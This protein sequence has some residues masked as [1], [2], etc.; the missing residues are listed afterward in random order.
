MDSTPVPYRGED[1]GPRPHVAVLFRDQIGDFL[2][3]TPL[4]RGLRERYPDLVLDYF[5]GERTRELEEASRLVDARYS[6]FSSA[7][8]LP[9]LAAFLDR[10]RSVAG[11]YT[12]AVNLESDP[13]AARG[14]G[15]IRPRFVCGTWAH[16]E[17]GALVPPPSDGIDRLW[18]DTWNRADL[19]A[20]YPPLSSQFIGEIFCRLCRVETAYAATETP[21]QAPGFETPSILISTGASRE[22]KLWPVAYW[23]DLVAWVRA[24]GL[25]VGLL[26]APPAAQAAYHADAADAAILA[27]GAVDLRG[28]LTLPEVAGAL[29]Q[30]RGFVTVD[31]G[32]MHMAA[33]V[34]TPTVAIF[35]A[36]PVRLWAPPFPSIHVL[37]PS[38][39]CPLCEENRFRNHACLIPIHRC[40]LSVEPSRVR[41]EL[42]ELLA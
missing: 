42:A 30:A 6:L 28:R 17:T 18:H 34:G 9:E 7:E 35:G 41:N 26:G 11:P 21:I 27:A 37:E 13:N 16:P 22:A 19:L 10:R 14:A 32:L 3:A 2:V 33:A 1:L 25:Q 40:M 15:A 12:L 20:D 31:N 24:Q 8:R 39:P 5:G 23:L 29:R 4:M 38:D 36:S